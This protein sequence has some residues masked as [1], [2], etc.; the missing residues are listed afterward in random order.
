MSDITRVASTGRATASSN[1]W[2]AGA[3]A[4][5]VSSVANLVIYF[6]VPALFNLSL[7][8][9]IMG[10][11]S[12]IQHMP[13]FQV[14]I[15]SVLTSFVAAGVLALLNRFT[16]RPITIFRVAAVVL[17]VLSLG[18]PFSMPVS[19]GIQLTLAAMHVVSAAI[20]AYFLTA[21]ERAA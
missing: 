4:A 5:L 8:I 18:A 12:E 15:V 14:I 16:A 11:G 6:A 7:D 9:P 10:P 21:G 3:L 17:L 19:L 20:I 1:L 13:F 2:V